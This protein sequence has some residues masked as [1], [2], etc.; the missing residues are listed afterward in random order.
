MKKLPRIIRAEVVIHG[1]L[2]LVWDDYYEGVVDLRPIIDRGQI[3]TYLQK[4]ENFVKF[5]VDEHGH[6]IGWIDE[7]GHEIDF[8]AYNLRQ[9]AENQAHLQKLVANMRV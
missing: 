3:F 1:V 6:S 5:K 4:R 8:D 7:E 9:K 2:K